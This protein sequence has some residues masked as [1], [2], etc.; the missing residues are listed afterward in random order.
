MSE[1]QKMAEEIVNRIIKN[2]DSKPGILAKWGK[3]WQMYFTDINVGYVLKM[4]M[5]GKVE[6]VDKANKKSAAA[7]TMIFD[8]P[9]TL[10]KMMDKKLDNMTAMST[11]KC[12]VEGPIPELMKISTAMM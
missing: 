11:G 12:K 3:A 6:K 9:D 5:D 7:V 1:K 8:T 2:V 4:G 10:V